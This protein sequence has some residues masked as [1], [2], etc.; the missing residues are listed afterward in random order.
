M[1]DAARICARLLR[2]GFARRDELPAL[3]HLELRHEVERRLA[4]V[5]LS[6]ATSA[7]SEHVGLR[8]SEA[9]ASEPDFDAA[10]NLGLRADALALLA[11]AW[12]RLALPK[13][14]A[15]DTREM[16][17]QGM[18]LAEDRADASRRFSPALRI[19]TL[20]REFRKAL[21]SRSNVER[22]VGQLRRLGFLGG[23]GE[24]IEAGPLLELAID[25]E[26]M[27]AWIRREVLARLL[28][29]AEAP[30][31]P[32]PPSFEEQL[33]EVLA[34]GSEPVP[35][36]QLEEETGRPRARLLKLL[37]ALEAEGR[38][39]RVGERART[40]WQAAR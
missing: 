18:L 4:G 37:K 7:Y 14:T 2:D 19:E 1:D 22:L 15:R 6:L 29:E 39:R 13:R 31:E 24:A 28:A 30:P 27:T 21:G 9:V 8:L 3:G 32:E 26:R 38:V 12:T 17:G 5:G 11:I 35:I 20:A 34:R 33:L 36:R 40:R 25:G 23:R 16:P 10:T